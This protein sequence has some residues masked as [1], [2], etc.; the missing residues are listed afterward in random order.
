MKNK[1]FYFLWGAVTLLQLCLLAAIR[2]LSIFAYR[3]GGV[4]HHVS[5]RKRQYN[6][7]LFTETNVTVMLILLSILL[8]VLIFLLVRSISG[9]RRIWT[10]LTL[11][12]LLFAA[13]LFLSLLLPPI[14][15][16]KVYP[17]LMLALFLCTLLSL[18]LILIYYFLTKKSTGSSP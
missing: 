17:Y 10:A 7:S 1:P 18:L 11:E 8:V 12:G 9:K 6:A 2:I 13:V 16:L 3:S 4:S 5:F 15:V 14:K